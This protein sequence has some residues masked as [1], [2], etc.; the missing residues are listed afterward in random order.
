[1]SANGTRYY[2]L[3]ITIYQL[4]YSIADT[5]LFTFDLSPLTL[6]CTMLPTNVRHEHLSPHNATEREKKQNDPQERVVLV[7][8][9]GFERQSRRADTIENRRRA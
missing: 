2:S 5:L 3:L 6:A 4:K 9:P 7:G 1:M 8:L